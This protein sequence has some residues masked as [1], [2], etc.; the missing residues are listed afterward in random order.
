V[1]D[2]IQLNQARLSIGAGDV[3]VCYTDGVTEAINSTGEAFGT[4]RLINL[5]R[6]NRTRTANVI[7]ELITTMLFQFT[8]G[9]LA[10]DVTLV[11]IRRL[12]S[13]QEP[14]VAEPADE[15]D[16]ATAA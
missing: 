1:L 8:G 4:E 14:S 7:L 16:S 10:D 11:I 3:L 2:E 5:I 15:R 12:E 13:E 6:D 9:P